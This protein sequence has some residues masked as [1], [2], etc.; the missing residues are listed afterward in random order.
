MTSLRRR[1]TEDMRVRNLSSHTQAT[2]V[3][4]RKAAFRRTRT[5]VGLR[6]ALYSSRGDL[7]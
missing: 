3:Q 6:R 2:Y 4:L 5:G 1:M 7:Q